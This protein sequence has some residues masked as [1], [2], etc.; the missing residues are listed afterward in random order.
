MFFMCAVIERLD[1]MLFRTEIMIGIPERD[2]GLLSD[3]AHGRLLVSA[4]TQ[5]IE[6]AVKNQR[7]G[8]LALHRLG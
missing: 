2:T 8:L 7:S 5:E 4:F 6:R 3:R 1:Q